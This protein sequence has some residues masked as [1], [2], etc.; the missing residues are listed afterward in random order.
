MQDIPRL[1]TA[2]AECSV[3]IVS[4]LLQNRVRLSARFFLKAGLFILVQCIFLICTDDVPL[5]LWPLCMVLAFLGMSIYKKLNSRQGWLAV[6]YY[7]MYD[8]LI[9][10]LLAS[11]EWQIEYFFWR[12]EQ[13]LWIYRVM[14]LLVIYGG[15]LSLICWIGKKI[16][17]FQ[18]T[19]EVTVQEVGVV[20]G[21]VLFAFVLGNL[22]FI[23][24]WTP[25]TSSNLTDIF[26]IRTLADAGGLAALLAY[27]SRINSLFVEQE[28]IRMNAVVASQYERYR[29]Y[30]NSIELVNIKYHDLKHQI[31][32][33]RGETDPVR[34][35]AWISR[36]EEEL[37]EFLPEQ[38][39]GSTVLD[40]LL[41]G[42]TRDFRK[43]QI[44][45]TCVADGRLLRG[46]FVTDICSIFGNALDNA[47][48]AVSLIEDP[49]KRMI[50]MTLTEKNGFILI[51]FMNTCAHE[52][53]VKVGIPVTTKK[54]KK[55]HGYGIRSIQRTAE[56]YGGTATWS[57]KNEMFELKVLLP[58]PQKQMQ[59]MPDF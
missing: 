2:L 23:F 22:S 53:E 21:L 28:L 10:E 7:T 31:S 58:M 55:Q 27:H 35:E 12:N 36:M 50:H 48:E 17:F 15:G 42:K 49:A 19:W 54:D 5:F 51:M 41:V 29:N 56:K 8:F 44:K 57:I 33:L 40:T 39:T 30:Q 38:Q 37:E 3:V 34:R 1:Y 14:F 13:V 24:P 16:C 43:R 18:R 11:L 26:T 32:G 45:F 25:F 6:F 20:L 46:L 47:V 9:A 52:L 4:T 59:D